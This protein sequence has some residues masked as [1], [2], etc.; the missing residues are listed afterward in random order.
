MNLF[1]LH[2]D[3]A[4]RLLAENQGLYKNT[5]HISLEK[6]EKFKSYA[7]VMAIWTHR[8]LTDAQGY[9]RFFEVIK[10]LENE[11]KINH[12]YAGLAK[13]SKDI[14]SL[15]SQDKRAL[16]VSVEDARILENDISRLDV[17]YSCGVRMMTLNWAGETC[18][19]GAHDTNTG[20]TDFGIRVVEKCFEKGIIPDISHSSFKGAKM[21]LELAVEHQKPI[22]ASHSNS[23]FV[24]HHTRNLQDDDFVTIQK[25]G[26]LVG[27]NLCP[28]HLSP[29]TDTN[30]SDVIKH[31]EHYISLGGENT[32]AF[33]CDL[34]GTNLPKG[35]ESI[36]DIE[37]II[38]EL[39]R[40]NYTN[41]LIEKISFSNALDFFN[42]TL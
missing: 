30:L 9:E 29:R 11:V 13:N 32:V 12:M 26:G 18:I 28:E 15:L 23:Y 5:F 14:N 41:E 20:L 16:I 39:G 4:T 3:T 21:A 7:Q 6:A 27:I 25:L 24:N 22:V 33:G 1:D 35:F 37:K 10:N 40:L 36:S 38:E 17:L 2:C 42:K 19:G 31:I 8:K 34:D